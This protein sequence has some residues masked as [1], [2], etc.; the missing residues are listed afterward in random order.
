MIQPSISLRS[1]NG[2]H[3]VTGA[4]SSLTSRD[5]DSAALLQLPERKAKGRLGERSIRLV[6]L[7]R[8]SCGAGE[9]QPEAEGDIKASVSVRPLCHFLFPFSKVSLLLRPYTVL[10]SDLNLPSLLIPPSF[11]LS[12]HL[13]LALG[14]PTNFPLTI[15]YSFSFFLVCVPDSTYCNLDMSRFL[16]ISAWHS[17]CRVKC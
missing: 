5:P 17:Q 7:L 13:F 6:S 9:G 4:S 3:Q 2:L 15:C 14:V 12:L 10:Y 8:G 11:L 16:F 1:L